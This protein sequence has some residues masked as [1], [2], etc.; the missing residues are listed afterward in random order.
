M[1]LPEITITP[2]NEDKFDLEVIKQHIPDSNT[3]KIIY[4]IIDKENTDENGAYKQDINGMLRNVSLIWAKSG[5]PKIYNNSFGKITDKIMRKLGRNP[6]EKSRAFALPGIGLFNIN[7]YQDLIA[8]ISHFYNNKNL[9][10][11]LNPNNQGVFTAITTDFPDKNGNDAYVIPFTMERITHGYTEPFLD[12]YVH[13]PEKG[14]IQP[15]LYEDAF[16]LT[17]QN[18]SLSGLNKFL[19]SSIDYERK[20]A[21]Q[22]GPTNSPI[23]NVLYNR[24]AAVLNRKSGGTLNYLKFFK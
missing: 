15:L 6:G 19:K 20:L 23:L 17:P 10:T 5:Q 11:S 9:G 2:S 21:A 1:D 22:E 3:R 12:A 18:R 8:E 14:S 13:Y 16:T 4:N 7:D 24:G